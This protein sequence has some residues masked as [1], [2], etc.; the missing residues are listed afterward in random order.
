MYG[1]CYSQDELTSKKPDGKFYIIN[2][3]AASEGNGTHWCALVDFTP[4]PC[5]IDPFGVVPPNL[6]I[7][8]MHK[9]KSKRAMYSK[10]QY[11]EV[12]SDKCAQFCIAFIDRLLESGGEL[13]EMDKGLS[14]EPSARNEA[15]AQKIRKKM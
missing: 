15:V 8:F 12:T 9:S 10:C 4:Y 11:Q 1:G 13:S 3:Q 6:V 2:V 7:D 14:E 5:W